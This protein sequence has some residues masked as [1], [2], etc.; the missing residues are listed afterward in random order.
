M[1]TLT[2]LRHAKSSWSQ[3]AEGP[4]VDDHDRALN[5]RGMR[6][7]PVMATH[8]KALGVRPQRVLCSTALRTRQTLDAVIDALPQTISVIYDRAL[9]LADEE[10]LKEA[11]CNAPEDVRTQL[12]IG[13]NPGLERLA[14][15][16]TGSGDE[17]ARASMA[18]KFPTAALAIIT[19]DAPAFSAITWGSGTLLHYQVPRAL[20][21]RAIDRDHRR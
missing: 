8:M 15:R 19:F 14:L 18:T 6:A 9:Y 17:I 21:H 3:P 16:L 20:D 1:L 10:T 5:K 11:L 4:A 12:L 13:H 2:L 7:A